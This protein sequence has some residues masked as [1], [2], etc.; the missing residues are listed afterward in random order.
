MKSLVSDIEPPCNHGD[1]RL[2]DGRNQ[3]HG[4]VEVCVLDIWGT[5]CDDSWDD[6]DAQVV[7]RQLGYHCKYIGTSVFQCNYNIL[8]DGWSD[9]DVKSG[10]QS[11]PIYLDDVNCIGTETSL[12]NCSHNGIGQHN[13][14]HSEDVGVVCSGTLTIYIYIFHS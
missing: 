8:I 4:R 9:N 5:V 12:L 7:C 13:C 1:V 10:F 2:V 11:Q 14:F 3:S 6:R